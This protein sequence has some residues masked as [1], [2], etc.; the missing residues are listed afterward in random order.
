MKRNFPKKVEEK[1]NIKQEINEKTKEILHNTAPKK[2]NQNKNFTPKTEIFEE[3]EDDDII[4][5]F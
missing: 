4:P 3:E 2:E 5:L 1:S